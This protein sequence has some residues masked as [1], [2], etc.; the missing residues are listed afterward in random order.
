MESYKIKFQDK[1][2]IIFFKRVLVLRNYTIFYFTCACLKSVKNN[3]LIT[4]HSEVSY[5]YSLCFELMNLKKDFND[6]FEFYSILH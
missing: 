2:R 5:C 1:E 3:I 6:M 4:Y